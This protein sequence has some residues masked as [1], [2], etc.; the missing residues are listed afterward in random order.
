[1]A[2]GFF[3]RLIIGKIKNSPYKSAIELC[4]NDEKEL[5]NRFSV[6]NNNSG[7]GKVNSDIIAYLVNEAENLP[8]K[9]SAVI[10][11]KMPGSITLKTESVESLI[12]DNIREQL[13]KT[14]KKLRSKNRYSI[15]LACIGMLCI[16]FTQVFQFLARRYSF[17]EFVIVISWVFMWKAVELFFFE[18]A[19]LMKEKRILMKLLYSE[20]VFHNSSSAAML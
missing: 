3:E 6:L 9:N 12:K 18:R 4:I 11:I 17:N 16:A 14:N 20:V 1:M 13:L 2:S 7:A 15:V 10:H 8:L 5:F 19:V